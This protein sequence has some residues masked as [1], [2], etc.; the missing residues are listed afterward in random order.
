LI[1]EPAPARS[2]LAF[3][4]TLEE[5]FPEISDPPPDPVEL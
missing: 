2:L 4:A 5:M 1:I 3:F